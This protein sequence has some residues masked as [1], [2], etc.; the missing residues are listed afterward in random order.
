LVQYGFTALSLGIGVQFSLFVGQ[1]AGGRLPTITRP[2][3]V[4]AYLPI[5][6]LINLKFWLVSGEFTRIHPAGTILLLVILA[7]GLF[8]KKAFCSWI[9]PVGLLSEQL[10]RFHDLLFRKPL[11]LPWWLDY[12]LRSLKYLLL[13]F[14][15]WAILVQMDASRLEKFI[16]SPYNRVADIKMLT[17]FTEMT[18]TT[19]WVL[20][21]LVLLS[22]V[23]RFFWCRF[24]CP[25][26][27][28]LGAL[29]WLS[30]LKIHRN[31]DTC[32]DC[33]NCTNVCPAQVKVQNQTV[34]FSDECHAC[35]NCVE[36]C[37]V[38]QTL[39]ISLTRKTGAVHPLAVGAAV[40]LLF[41]GG[42]ILG[43][44]LGLWHN[45]ITPEE[46]LYHAQRLDS[47]VYT[48]NRG[49]VPDQLPETLA[50]PNDRL[51][52]SPTETERR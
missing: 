49:E 21:A 36:V 8:L 30:P 14:F 31:R 40:V 41:L 43:R 19:F 6:S 47:P 13:L 28:L 3:G 44:A 26:G 17:F 1:L 48:H 38:P 51:T 4:E 45:E 52:P 9:C 10:S 42:T 7:S 35:C 46:Y 33:G 2:P 50:P 22:V 39:K 37:P 27:A 16:N 29:S 23:V 11:R 20:V 12:P 15:L 25:Y 32:T 18:S 24:L 34:V 5:S